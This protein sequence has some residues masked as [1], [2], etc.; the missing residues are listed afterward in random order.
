MLIT[1]FIPYL[2]TKKNTIVSYKQERVSFIKKIKIQNRKSW[3]DKKFSQFFVIALIIYIHGINY[4]YFANSEIWNTVIF[5]N[6]REFG[7]TAKTIEERIDWGIFNP[8]SYLNTTLAVFISI[9]SAVMLV[10]P[11]G[12]QLLR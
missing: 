9:I 7:L 5:H 2:K 11:V 3:W 12:L 4:N 1:E 10:C 8:A 6:L